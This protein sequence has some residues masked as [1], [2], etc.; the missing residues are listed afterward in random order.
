M[1]KRTARLLLGVR[2]SHSGTHKSVLGTYCVGRGTASQEHLP[3]AQL[4]IAVS[5]IP[6][7]SGSKQALTLKAEELTTVEFI[8]ARIC[9]L[10][11][12]GFMVSASDCE[13]KIVRNTGTGRLTIRYVFDPEVVVFAKLYDDNLGIHCYEV[14]QALWKHGFNKSG[15]YRVPQPLG[16]FAD[17]AL[18][19]MLGVQGTPLGAAFD[20]DSS[21]DLVSGSRE[22][23]EWLAAL[24]LSTLRVGSPDLDLDSLKQYCMADRVI[25]TIAGRPDKM[26]LVRELME[27][28]EHRAA[29]LTADRCSVLTHGRYHHDHVFLMPEAT[30]VID[31]D[32]CRPSDP[33]KDVAEFIRM[34]RLTAFKEGFAMERAE[35]AISAF[36]SSYLAILPQ[37]ADSLGCYWATFV[38]HSLIRGLKQSR[39]N[40][41][42]SWEQIEDFHEQ[43]IKRALDFGR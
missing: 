23:A 2:P 16:F 15:R 13:T 29:K 18:L 11:E 12:P 41:N 3:S 33:A 37:T 31:L 36:L 6:A 1:T 8:G 10:L 20:G 14:N 7:P 4:P 40:S 28:L 32:R 21:V 42:K 9:P 43:E 26:D 24:H 17:H 30:S 35:L 19:L 27:M 38:F 39:N 25:K 22:A 34:L 5:T